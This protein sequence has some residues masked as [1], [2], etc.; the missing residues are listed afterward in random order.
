MNDDLVLS[1][2]HDGGGDL[3]NL[4][5]SSTISVSTAPSTLTSTGHI[6]NATAF[7]NFNLAAI[8]S[9]SVQLQLKGT[10]VVTALVKAEVSV[11]KVV[12][13]NGFNNFRVPP[14]INSLVR[15]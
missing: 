14:V 8:T 1:W 12:K 3:V 9:H 2:Q 7:K 13:L 15:Y 10:A 5:G 11:N 4:K 6:K